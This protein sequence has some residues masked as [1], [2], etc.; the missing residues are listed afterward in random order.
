[1]LLLACQTQRRA[2]ASAPASNKAAP[3]PQGRTRTEQAPLQSGAPTHAMVAPAAE[4]PIGGPYPT[5]VERAARD[6]HWL[7]FC[8]ATRDTD[9][10]GQPRVSVGPRGE[11]SGD[12]L[13]LY[14][15]LADHVAQPVDA[16]WAVDPTERWLLVGQKGRAV[17]I[18]TS[19][20]RRVEVDARADLEEWPEAL[21]LHR[22]FAFDRQ[23]GS[24]LVYS[25]PTSEG[26]ELRSM[27]LEPG[28]PQALFAARG[29]LSRLRTSYDGAWW[30]I[31]SVEQDTNQN[32]R[33]DLPFPALKGKQRCHAPLASFAAWPAQGD[34]IVTRVRSTASGKVY[35]VEDFAGPLGAG[36]L[37]RDTAGALFLRLAERRVQLAP[38][39]CG[40][41]V[42]H[43][44][45]ERG[46][47][48]IACRGPQ[49]PAQLKA[50]QRAR[51][52][53]LGQAPAPPRTR[54]PLFLVGEGVHLDLGLEIGPTGSD[55]WAEMASRLVPIHA[56][57]ERRLLDLQDKKLLPL[58]PRE[59]VLATFDT[60]TLIVRPGEVELL[61]AITRQRFALFSD[62]D[63]FPGVLVEEGFAFVSP[64]L[65][66]LGESTSMGK[67]EGPVYAL[68]NDGRLLQTREA[69][70]MNALPLG[71]LYWRA[72]TA[73]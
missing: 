69:A 59:S 21:P 71:P 27:A 30:V 25:I 41:Q 50:K 4:T 5:T 34:E 43:A 52:R 64:R 11:L 24:R 45:A 73:P 62:I 56:G 18:D 39:D 2:I 49:L 57:A 53:R 68:S 23:G 51:Q 47:V 44:D 17:A 37:F 3:P 46:L 67:I 48:L 7:L 14:L 58:G 38:A 26:F 60:R 33:L 70:G 31:E 19:S 6:R 16:L 54:L 61:D 55:R 40:A 1:M 29:R 13:E 15:A 28:L 20:G 35:R 12:A 36:F 10:N 32:G 72:P 65:I 22:A 8:Q 42:I 9:G 63:A 66:A